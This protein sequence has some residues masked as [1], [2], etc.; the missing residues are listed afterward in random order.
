[1]IAVAPYLARANLKSTSPRKQ[2]G[3]KGDSAIT[4]TKS[5]ITY[6]G[7]ASVSSETTNQ[8]AAAELLSS[9]GKA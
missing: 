8:A 1:M 7:P 9:F 2:N 6:A 5:T 4:A 3:N